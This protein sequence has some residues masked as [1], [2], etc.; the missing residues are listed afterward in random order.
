M[1]L[2]LDTC[3][4]LWAITDAPALSS[5]ARELIA[6]PG[7]EVFLSSVS[8]WEIAVKWNRGRL[9]LAEAP[10][11]F[12]PSR[13]EAHGME[14]L[15]FDE[16]SASDHGEFEPRYPPNSQHRNLGLRRRTVAV[17]LDARIRFPTHS[18]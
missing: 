9:S 16:V 4:F 8:A 15:P 17:V 18:D 2:L 5:R 14:A 7:N 12:V 10:D 1:K 11:R 13:R 3:T 6:A